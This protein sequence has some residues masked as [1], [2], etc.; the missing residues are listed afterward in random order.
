MLE[1]ALQSI[2]RQVLN[3]D[4]LVDVIPNNSDVDV[5]V[6]KRVVSARTRHSSGELNLA[7]LLPW[8][9]RYTE[10]RSFLP[11]MRNASQHCLRVG[12]RWSDA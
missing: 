7:Q 5:R 9:S 3:W 10:L 2:V 12:E 4:L 1:K 8:A 6:H 11:H